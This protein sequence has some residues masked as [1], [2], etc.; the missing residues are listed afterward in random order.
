MDGAWWRGYGDLD[1][2]Q[3]KVMALPLDG[4]YFVDGPP[5][6]GKTN[7]LLLRANFATLSNRKNLR[8][9]VFNQTLRGFI[10]RGSAN[11]EFDPAFVVTSTQLL[12][13][14]VAQEGGNILADGDIQAARASYI[15]QVCNLLNGG[16]DPPFDLLFLDEAQDYGSQ[17]LKA[18]AGLARNLMI[19]ADSRQR[20]YDVEVSDPVNSGLADEVLSLRFHYRN[21]ERVCRFADSIGGHF[22]EGYA[23][24]LPTSNYDEEAE[25]SKVEFVNGPFDEQIRLLM[26]QLAYQIRTYGNEDLGILTSSRALAEA[27]YDQL[28]ETELAEHLNFQVRAEDGGYGELDPARKIWISTIH[29]AKGMEFRAVHI[30]SAES[31][32]KSGSSQKRLAYTAVTRAK[33]S[34]TVYHERPL[35]PYLATAVEEMQGRR[36]AVEL[37]SAFGRKR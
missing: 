31:I 19:V 4:R 8:V 15:D 18:L 36:A 33:T 3:K 11:Y 35:P 14:V 2:D 1:E 20:I 12:R 34:L 27:V 37:E 7:L 21:G 10:G 26:E 9:V 24:I 5:G 16:M 13:A 6:S 28:R 30:L 32:A 29:G 23:P 22:S 17:E 25:P